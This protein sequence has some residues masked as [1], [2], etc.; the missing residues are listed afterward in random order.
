[1]GITNMMQAKRPRLRLD[2]EAYRELRLKTL[3]RDGWRCQQC[4]AMKNLQVHHIKPRSHLGHDD[5][6]N[7][8]TLCIG[9][10]E[11]A[12]EKGKPE[13]NFT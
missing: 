10:H 8:V 5:I 4:G 2:P 11:W 7:L 13:G 9:C 12:H 6:D 3:E 1:M